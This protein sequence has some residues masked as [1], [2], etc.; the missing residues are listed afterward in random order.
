MR[1]GA[2][3]ALAVFEGHI[4]QRKGAFELWVDVYFLPFFLTFFT[5][6]VNYFRQLIYINDSC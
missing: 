6:S 5:I 4:Q 3:I 2:V 1:K